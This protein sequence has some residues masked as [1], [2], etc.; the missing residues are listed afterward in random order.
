MKLALL[1]VGRLKDE[2]EGRIVDRYVERFGHMAG[3]LG[4][5]P[6]TVVELTESKARSDKERKS[7]EAAE[8]RKKIPEGARIIALDERGR[9]LTSTEFA[10]LLAEW[11]DHGVRHASVVIG[12][13]DGLAPDFAREASLTLSLGRL[14]MPHGLARAVIVEQIYRAATIMARHPYHRG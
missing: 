3:Q 11:R 4:F 7:A 9:S 1:C 8:L 14:T 6:L 2:A 10:E 13:P 12:G 5:A